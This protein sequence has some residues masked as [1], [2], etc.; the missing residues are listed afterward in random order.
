[1]ISHNAVF[2]Y[3]KNINLTIIHY[4]EDTIASFNIIL[5]GFIWRWRECRALK[6]MILICQNKS[7]L[8]LM[9]TD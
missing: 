1:M 8:I 4:L 2:K 7:P 3:K 5:N 6:T 9:F